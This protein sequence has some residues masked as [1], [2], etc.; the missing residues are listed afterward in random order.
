MLPVFPALPL[1][2]LPAAFAET[3]EAD[4]E[5]KKEAIKERD[6]Q[7]LQIEREKKADP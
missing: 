1:A 5:E 3:K 6:R 4:I 2:A 7:I